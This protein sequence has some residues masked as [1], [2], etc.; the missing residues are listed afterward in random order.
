MFAERVGTLRKRLETAGLDALVCRLPENVLCLTGYWPRSG[1]SFLVVTAEGGARLVLPDLEAGLATAGVERREFSWGRLDDPPP[2]ESV[3]RLLAPEGRALRRVGWEANFEAVA[4]AHVAG[5][6]LVPAAT[7]R[8]MLQ[9]VFPEAQLEDATALLNDERAR[10]TPGDL[11]GLARAAQVAERGV[12]AFERS[13][14][15]GIREC[16]LQAAVEAAVLAEGPGIQGAQ[17]VRAFAQLLSGPATAGA[18][19]PWY[20]PTRRQVRAGELV[21]LELATVADG[22]WSDITRVAVAGTPDP[23]QR[24]VCEAVTHALEAARAAARPGVASSAVD[25]A[26][27]AVLQ[28]AGLAHAFVHHTGHGVGFRYHEPRPWIHPTSTH[29]LEEGMVTTLEPGAYVPGRGGI[30]LE[31]NVWIGPE[32]ART[33]SVAARTWT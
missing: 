24:Q 12:L 8:A 17:S 18:W 21:L 15:P 6:V 3:R 32:G 28:E 19:A 2:L 29:T 11:A 5:E 31:E 7:T 4:P 27:R 13:V 26:A 10:K 25:A 30:R 33:L 23:W 20:L 22:Y 9:E 1:V 16:E 14:R